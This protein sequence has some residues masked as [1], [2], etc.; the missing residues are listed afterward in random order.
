M[1]NL[2]T[3]LAIAAIVGGAGLYI[4]KA[5]K[6]G[7]KCIGCP[8]GA[9]CGKQSGHGCSGSCASCSGCAHHQK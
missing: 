6:R 5:K 3:F 9:D 2:I 7:V 8:S 4:Y 1:V